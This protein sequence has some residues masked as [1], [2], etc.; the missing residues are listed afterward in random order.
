MHLYA[1]DVELLFTQLLPCV[2]T[3]ECTR[4]LIGLQWN[5]SAPSALNNEVFS[6]SYVDAAFEE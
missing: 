5:S 4:V 2:C 1:H 6:G 3:C